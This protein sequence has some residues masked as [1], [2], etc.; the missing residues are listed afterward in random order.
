MSTNS[1]LPGTLTS[2]NA[3]F[4]IS[5]DI[6]NFASVIISYTSDSEIK[7]EQRIATLSKQRL[8]GETNLKGFVLDFDAKSKRI[9]GKNDNK[10]IEY[11]WNTDNSTDNETVV[12]IDN[13]GFTDIEVNDNNPFD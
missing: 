1:D 7:E 11:S 9:Y 5:G 12:N 3:C 4:T 6:P 10:D 13:N 2:N 8:F